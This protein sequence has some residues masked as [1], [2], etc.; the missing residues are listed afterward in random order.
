MIYTVT[1][2]PAIDYVVRLSAPLQTGAV[3]R[4][5]GE[6]CVLG[7]KGINVSGVL[8]QLDCPSVALGFVAGETGAWLERGLAAQGLH[9]DFI[10]LAAGMTRI[11]V[12]IKAGQETEL[13][14]AG[15]AIPPEAMAEL[16]RKLDALERDDLLV[17]AGSIPAS[18]PA[19]TYE[20]ILARLQGRGVR[21]VVDAA[22]PLLAKVL[23]YGPFL[24]KPNHHELAEIVGRPLQGDAQITQAARDLQQRGARNVLV[25]MAGDGALLLDETGQVHRI[26]TP[27]GTV[28]NS[29]GAGDSMLAG[30]LAGYLQSG[31]YETALRLGTACGSATAFSL[32][33][34]T[35][36][37]ID[38]L[39]TQL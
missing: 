13:N 4:A 10:H 24:I 21:A 16:Y 33:L 9:T 32:G 2:N 37:E 23:P 34:A 35:R 30:F 36:S 15:P 27:Q 38:A 26:G 12:K 3:N 22:G 5:A 8:A 17:L 39:L 28:I 6:D 11:N 20:K 19:D 29:V 18:L 1:F 25:S 31:S 7:G 14:G